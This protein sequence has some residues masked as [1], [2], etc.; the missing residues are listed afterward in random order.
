MDVLSSKGVRP[1]M[2]FRCSECGDSFSGAEVLNNEIRL[3]ILIAHTTDPSK[4]VFR[5]ELCQEAW[6]E[7]QLDELEY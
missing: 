5:C 7:R 6:L 3:H 4:S 2:E 1:E